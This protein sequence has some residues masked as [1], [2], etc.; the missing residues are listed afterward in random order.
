MSLDHFVLAPEVARDEAI[1]PIVEQAVSFVVSEVGPARIDAVILTGSLSR[2]EGSLLATPSGFRLL[3]DVEFLVV[4]KDASG[5]PTIRRQMADVSR[6]AT[7]SLGADGALAGIEYGPVG[8]AYFPRKM[9][10]SIF[11]FDLLTHGKVLWGR[12]EILDEARTFPVSA[13]PPEDAIA[14]IMNRMVELLDIEDAEPN[15][16]TRAYHGVKIMLDLAGSVL[17]FT[18]RHV[19]SYAGRPE[20]FQSLV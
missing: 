12:R 9:Q 11:A 13:I 15:P 19:S 14:L 7:S 20:P 18:G 4:F 2:G 6:R 3:G 10:P 8:P 16:Q 1:R 17:A 5:W